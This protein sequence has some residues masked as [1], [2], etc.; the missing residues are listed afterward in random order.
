[1]DFTYCWRTIGNAAL[2][3]LTIASLLSNSCGKE[4]NSNF[5]TDAESKI[6]SHLA[7]RG[8]AVHIESHWGGPK[9]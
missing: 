6:A 3:A 8:P 9:Q 5:E 4:I 1:M 7:I 2:H